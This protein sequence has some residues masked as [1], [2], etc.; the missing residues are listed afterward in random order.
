[1]TF[2][3]YALE[4]FYLFLGVLLLLSEGGGLGEI[5]KALGFLFKSRP[6]VRRLLIALG[7]AVAALSVFF[8]ADPG[9]VLLGDFLVTAT[10][11]CITL[12]L[13]SRSR[14]IE[15]EEGAK[16]GMVDAAGAFIESRRKRMARLVLVVGIIHFIVP[17]CVLL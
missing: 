3:V 6:A 7:A 16:E 13:A 17:G 15:R 10:V 5:P 9:P 1:M 11:L 14:A 8:P 4:L 12:W 2:P